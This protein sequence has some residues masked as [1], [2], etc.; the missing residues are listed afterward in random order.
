MPP[1][2]MFGLE[3]QDYDKADVVVLP[4]PY[5]STTTYKAGARDGPHAMI[6]ASRSM[7]FYNE[8]FGMD[9]S[10]RIHIF[11]MDEL[12]PSL[13]SPGETVN[14]IEREVEII[15]DN[16]KLPVLIGGEHTIA[17]GSI[18]AVSKKL[19]KNF[20]VLHF[21]AH[22]DYRD[23]Y[24]GSKY[25]H[26]CIMARA[27]E[28]CDTC[29]SVGIRSIDEVSASKYEKD[30]LYRKEMRKMS[31]EEI[32]AQILKR[33]KEN[34]YITIDLDVIDPSEMPSTGTPEPDGLSFHELT[35]ILKGVLAKRKLVGID[36]NELSPI[37]GVS[38]PNY[39]AAKL[40]YMTLG[41]AFHER[42]AQKK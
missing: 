6:E 7:E 33:T 5:D 21:D 30:I 8:E 23:E 10:K 37:G 20:S 3:E 14:R 26:A 39:L 35:S 18:R 4:I 15:L 19:K 13:D 11:T 31:I 41:Y 32:V 28:A 24:G 27:R 29:Y 42:L 34:L 12:E 1:Y 25:C 40:V 38:Y 36:F 2:N 9:I 17:V 22:S 16:K